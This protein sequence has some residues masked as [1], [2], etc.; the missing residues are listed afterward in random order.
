MKQ[1]YL[2]GLFVDNKD[3][4]RRHVPP[5]HLLTFNG[6]YDVSQEIELFLTVLLIVDLVTGALTRTCW[7]GDP[8]I[9]T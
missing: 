1:L 2:L 8:F 7:T 3:G 6:L 5:K 9:V 4:D